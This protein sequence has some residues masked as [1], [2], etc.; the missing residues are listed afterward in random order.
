MA[1]FGEDIIPGS[2]MSSLKRPV[3]GGVQ[4]DSVEA[5]REELNVMREEQV[6]LPGYGIYLLA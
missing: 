5:L 1:S 4:D 6:G 2:G 3:P